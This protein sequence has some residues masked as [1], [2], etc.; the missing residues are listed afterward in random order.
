M[1]L[2]E[3]LYDCRYYA[4]WL[5]LVNECHM[6]VHI[7]E[8]QDSDLEYF[9]EYLDQLNRY[10]NASLVRFFGVCTRPG[11][12]FMVL[13]DHHTKSIACMEEEGE[14]IDELQVATLSLQ[15]LYSINFLHTHD[16]PRCLG[17]LEEREVYFPMCF[18]LPYLGSS[19]E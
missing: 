11:N 2:L 5:A 12:H 14:F 6:L 4:V 19:C 16:R 18:V 17:R 1:R 15:L 3:R 10:Y 7:Y 13:L 9:L 8:L